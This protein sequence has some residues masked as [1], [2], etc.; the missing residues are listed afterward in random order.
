LLNY[1]TFFFFFFFLFLTRKMVTNI[2]NFILVLISQLFHNVGSLSLTDRLE[3][4][5]Q[6]CEI[7]T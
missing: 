2:I 3:L 1:I 7:K 4:L 6:Y 5:H